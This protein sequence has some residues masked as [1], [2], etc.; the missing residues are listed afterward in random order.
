MRKKYLSALLFGA[1]LFASAGTFTSC[2]D[3]DDDINNL[4]GQITANADAIKALQE[5]VNS[6]KYVSGVAMEGQTI[7][8][9]FSD[10][11][12][13]AVVIPEGEKGQ[14]VVVKDG[15]LYIDDE[16][17]GI[18]VA[19]ELETE[20]GLVKAENGTWWVLNENGEY[21]N[22]NIPVSG[23]T[24]SGSEKDG[25]TFT[26]Y[27]EKGEAQTVKLPTA[28]SSITSV[29]IGSV[30][31]PLNYYKGTFKFNKNGASFIS[32]RSD[33]KGVKPLPDDNDVIYSLDGTIPVRI[34]PVNVDATQVSFYLTNTQNEDVL[35]FVM[36][37]T[38]DTNNGKPHTT[39]QVAG[40]AAQ[41]NGL[42]KVGAT[43]LIVKAAD[44]NSVEKAIEDNDENIALALNAG[45]SCRSAYSLTLADAANKFKTVKQIKL[46][47]DG[48]EETI[49]TE[50]NAPGTATATT[51][52]KY[53][54]GKAIKVSAVESES[55]YDMYL[56]ADDQDI[57]DY[58]LV[59]DQEK[60]TVTIGKNPDIESLTADF[61]LI[62][63]TLDN[64][65]NIKKITLTVQLSETMIDATQ[66]ELVTHD[67][68][69]TDNNFFGIDLAT[70]KTNLGD[71]LDAWL[72]NVN[73]D[74]TTVGIYTDKDCTQKLANTGEIRKQQQNGITA[75]L[76]ETVK[77][78]AKETTDR[79]K[80]KYIQVNIDNSKVKYDIQLGQT[81]YLKA[82]FTTGTA[83]LSSLVVPVVFT[84]PSLTEQFVKET[85]VFADNTAMAYLNYE[86]QYNT[87]AKENTGYMAYAFRHAFKEMPECTTTNTITFALADND[88]V[89]KNKPSTEYA[90]IAISGK[91]TA[92]TY[93]ATDEDIANVKIYIDKTK[94]ENDIPLGYGKDLTVNVSQ[95]YFADSKFK[96]DA[97]KGDDKYTFKINVKSPIYEGT[98]TAINSVVTIPA[99]GS[100]YKLGNS[101]IKGT[102]YNN[103]DYN[104]MPD[105]LDININNEAWKAGY[106][107]TEALWS[108][109]E[110]EGVTVVSKTPTVI[111]VGNK[112]NNA[113]ISTDGETI[114]GGYW[115]VKPMNVNTE[116]Q[117]TVSVIVTDIWGL[118][119]ANDI[120]VTVTRNE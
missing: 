119:K 92:K 72:Q 1:L 60:H 78:G 68:S 69:D 4:Q 70:M 105:L 22:T 97:T 109:N 31:T 108:R 50:L 110:I 96:Y 85:A 86:D 12:T 6:G 42:Y 120:T 23:I 55:L 75:I 11:S 90:T 79:N 99:T 103:I 7:T 76:V 66:Y 102:T 65:G 87:T 41:G 74:A 3:Y 18:K 43:G 29:I 27:N 89:A 84:A 83:E 35:P 45:H 101:D 39:G 62:V 48:N 47:Q 77:N 116:G 56:T 5:L 64:L 32:S 15:E 51:R 82:T 118:S 104:V 81:Y 107:S 28:A 8:F 33:W 115:E 73:L 59:F 26:I 112:L 14:T 21:T 71:N 106:V 57:K 13:Q 114:V 67:V 34:N 10:G 17:T 20:V 111:T 63:T 53:V 93:E 54:V 94:A 49:T 52:D 44:A 113:S 19:E 38:E 117:G 46:T 88:N 98:V 25:Y 61:D 30:T 24:V 100:N 80:A 36:T 2:K 95:T 91:S 40:R 9:T 58:G 37:A 16:A